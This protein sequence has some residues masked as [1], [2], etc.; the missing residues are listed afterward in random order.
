MGES[1]RCHWNVAML[2]GHEQES[3]SIQPEPGMGHSLPSQLL[4]CSPDGDGKI[5]IFCMHG[6]KTSKYPRKNP[7][8]LGKVCPTGNNQKSQPF[9]AKEMQP[10]APEPSAGVWG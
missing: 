3:Q 6:R 9:S 1:S 7:L 4:R 8:Q 10:G 2:E 5:G